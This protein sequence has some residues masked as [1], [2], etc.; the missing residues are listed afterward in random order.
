MHT[1]HT[2]RTAAAFAYASRACIYV[3]AIRQ[4]T[5]NGQRFRDCMRAGGSFIANDL[6]ALI[7]HGRKTRTLS[8]GGERSRGGK[9]ATSECLLANGV[10]SRRMWGTR[11]DFGAR[12]Y[13]LGNFQ[14]TSSRTRGKEDS[15]SAKGNKEQMK[16]SAVRGQKDSC[17]RFLI[18]LLFPV[19]LLTQFEPF[20][21]SI[22][23]E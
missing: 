15:V 14:V 11:G 9:R 20:K 3:R 5:R 17:G 13:I 22:P 23:F 2:E 12:C 1:A 4:Q 18:S 7:P 21:A 6:I 8:R 16:N 19:V 10:R